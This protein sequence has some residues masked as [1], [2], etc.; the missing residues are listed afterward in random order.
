ML[1]FLLTF[2]TNLTFRQFTSTQSQTTGCTRHTYIPQIA[3]FNDKVTQRPNFLYLY[4]DNVNLLVLKVI[5][6]KV[7]L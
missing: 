1:T 4:L 6:T 7:F 2:D 5:K 3:I